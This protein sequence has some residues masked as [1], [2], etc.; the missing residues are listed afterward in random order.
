MFRL[1][2]KKDESVQR[3][4]V[5]RH[6]TSCHRCRLHRSG[7]HFLPAVALLC[8]KGS[9]LD[10]LPFCRLTCLN[11]TAFYCSNWFWRKVHNCTMCGREVERFPLCLR[12]IQCTLC[13]CAYVKSRWTNLQCIIMSFLLLDLH[14]QFNEWKRRS[15]KR[16]KTEVATNWSVCLQRNKVENLP[17]N[18]VE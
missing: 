4:K 11:Y 12:Y 2:L 1:D 9:T 7:S 17:R 18:Q 13:G 15:R 6:H 10:L 8:R 14:V 3:S 16:C 5:C